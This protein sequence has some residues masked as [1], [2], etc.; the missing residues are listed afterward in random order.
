MSPR[1]FLE[2]NRPQTITATGRELPKDWKVGSWPWKE[3]KGGS[4]WCYFMKS[5]SLI[6]SLFLSICRVLLRACLGKIW[7]RIP[8]YYHQK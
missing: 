3:G 7:S 6:C 5:S 2:E 8:K 1:L 4:G